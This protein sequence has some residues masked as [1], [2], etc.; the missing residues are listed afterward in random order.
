MTKILLLASLVLASSASAQELLSYWN[1]NNVEAGFTDDELGTWKTSPASF[2]E[3]YDSSTMRLAANTGSSAVFSGENVYLDLSQLAGTMGGPPTKAWGVFTDTD[4][5]RVL[6]DG[7]YNES[8]GGSFMTGRSSSG[9][10]ITFVVSSRGYDRL[11]FS[12]AGRGYNEGKIEWSY[13][14]DGNT[15]TPLEGI[16]TLAAFSKTVVNLSDTDGRGLNALDNQ[17]TV[18]LRATFVMDRKGGTVTVALDNFQFTGFP[19]EK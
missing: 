11:S 4:K 12:Y 2:G 6:Y 9:N 8:D 1:F 17:D 14:T 15:F 18:Y 19:I 10:P 13:S 5:N 3:G 7:S 16:E